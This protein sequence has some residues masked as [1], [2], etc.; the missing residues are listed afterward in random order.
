MNVIRPITVE[1]ENRKVTLNGYAIVE[2]KVTLGRINA[3]EEGSS[4]ASCYGTVFSGRPFLRSASID[5]AVR[6]E[7][8]ID[9]TSALIERAD[10][11]RWVALQLALFDLEGDLINNER[12]QLKGKGY[13]VAHHP[14]PTESL[15]FQDLGSRLPG[16]SLYQFHQ[17]ERLLYGDAFSYYSRWLAE[18]LEG[19]MVNFP[20]GVPELYELEAAITDF[21]HEARS[22][23]MQAVIE[24]IEMN[25]QTQQE[26]EREKEGI[27]LN[28]ELQE[29]LFKQLPL[30]DKVLI[31]LEHLG[32][33]YQEL[34]PWSCRLRL[35]RELLIEATAKKD[36]DYQTTSWGKNLLLLTFLW[37][38][39]R[40]VITV[41]SKEGKAR[42]NLAFA[43]ILAVTHVWEN[44]P[45]DLLVDLFLNWDE[46]ALSLNRAALEGKKALFKD[47]RLSLADR[48]RHIILAYLEG[49][50]VAG[51]GEVSP[52]ATKVN[53][54]FLHLLPTRTEKHGRL[55]TCDEQ[56]GEAIALTEAGKKLL[57]PL[58]VTGHF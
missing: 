13:P 39:L 7:G 58:L 38:E 40:C 37:L 12:R 19:V 35:Y 9:I 34:K 18:E 10:S 50:S 20:K 47:P 4:L 11:N 5:T 42:S 31:A 14:L 28:M 25:T 45:C 15:Y 3:L 2:G 6:S 22:P 1:L 41:N 24:K 29:E 8:F 17:V 26:M 36:E 57:E 21:A 56:T 55:I 23:L 32:D 43:V 33:K 53:S 52:L 51:S 48:L 16:V 30:I 54:D 46:D 27:L 49:V 44:A